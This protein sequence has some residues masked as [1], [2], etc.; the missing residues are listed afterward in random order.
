MT[1]FSRNLSALPVP[2][3]KEPPITNVDFAVPS[4]RLRPNVLQP[5]DRVEDVG[6]SK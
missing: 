3:T 2:T 5:S 6:E 1:T 4:A